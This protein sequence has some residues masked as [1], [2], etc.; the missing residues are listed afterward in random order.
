MIRALLF[1]GPDVEQSCVTARADS[2]LCFTLSNRSLG[3]V[4]VL[5][6]IA[7]SDLH[8]SHRNSLCCNY[9]VLNPLLI[10]SMKP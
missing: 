1:S 3:I 9:F 7:T 2:N 4:F 10:Q 6:S 8:L 5:R